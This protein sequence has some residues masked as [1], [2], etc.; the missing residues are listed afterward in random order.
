MH[1]K[2]TKKDIFTI[3]NAMSLFRLLLIP[4]II[5]LYCGK[6]NYLW[7]AVVIAL[8]AA[9]DIADGKI[10]RRF[11]MVSDF[12]KVLDPVADKLTQMT[13]IIC[14]LSRYS[15]LWFLLALF[16]VKE[17]L[18]AFWGYLTIKL[19]DSINS[20]RWYGKLSTVILYSSMIILF[21]F[22]RVSET[23]AEVLTV[24]C[25]FVMVLSL[26]GYGNFY[27]SI[28]TKEVLEKKRQQ[29][30]MWT[31]RILIGLIWV[32]I[33]VLLFLHKKDFTVE[34]I[35]KFTPSN[36]VLAALTMLAL[37]A[38]K[39]ISIVLYSG[40]LYAVNGILFPLPVAI[41]LNILGIA[42]M[43]T[44]PYLIGKKAG[45]SSVERIM[46][47]YPKA[48]KMREFRKQNDFIFV[49]MMRVMGILP[50]DIVSLYM[51]AIG[52]NYPRYL[53]ACLLGMLRSA[54]TFP[55]MGM[56]ITDIH[57]PLFITALCV[58]LIFMATSILIYRI[59]RKKH[60]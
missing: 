6:Q 24:A 58:E 16:V 36:P 15:W 11:S 43:V 26:V 40:I 35:L 19:T 39:S 29:I 25:A 27:R 52:V 45:S 5:W 47:K 20:A 23:V 17:A 50:S 7:A 30:A 41:L 13:L 4:V 34:E 31:W 18:M 3:P 9:T 48:D 60:E 37:F 55:I 59:Y 10:A 2:F 12:G 28:L 42:V 32:A 21:L 53:L 56:S 44:I 8:S 54:I 49:L 46:E 38:L 22:P 57:S 1:Y 51:G 14:L 33:I